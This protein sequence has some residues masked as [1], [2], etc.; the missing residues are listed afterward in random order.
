[1]PRRRG[2]RVVRDDRRPADCACL[3]E[4]KASDSP[5]VDASSSLAR[6]AGASLRNKRLPGSAALLVLPIALFALG[7]RKLLTL[8]FI[9]GWQPVSSWTVHPAL[10]AI[11]G[12]ALVA[13]STLTIVGPRRDLGAWGLAILLLTWTVTLQGPAVIASPT[14]VALW[15]GIAEVGALI[16]A[17]ILIAV[18]TGDDG[19]ESS[20]WRTGAFLAFGTC[21]CVF[22]ISH[23][24]YIGFTATMVPSWMPARTPLAYLTGAAHIAAGVAIGSGIVRRT[25]ALLLTLMMGSFILLVHLPA[26][27]AARASLIEVTFLLNACAL[28]GSALV[29]ARTASGKRPALPSSEARQPL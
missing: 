13:L 17:S 1:V 22:G 19:P 6:D 29:V 23:F 10:A 16:A 26:V 14:V 25:A 5:T 15:L 18:S 7:L 20:Q 4:Q 24:A 9:P 2:R 28:F 12:M 21:C 11:D 27:I 3:G 8:T